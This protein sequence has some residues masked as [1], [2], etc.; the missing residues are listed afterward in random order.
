LARSAPR[1]I[2]DKGRIE[3]AGRIQEAAAIVIAASKGSRR[4]RHLEGDTMNIGQLRVNDRCDPGP[5]GARA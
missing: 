5:G 1:R 2:A 4:A 3:G